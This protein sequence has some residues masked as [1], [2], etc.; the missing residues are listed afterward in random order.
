MTNFDLT[1]PRSPSGRIETDLREAIRTRALKPGD[2]LDTY[3]TL[4]QQYGVDK[5]TVAAAVGRL[6]DQRLVYTKRGVGT[7]VI[8]QSKIGADPN[9]EAALD[10]E[11]SESLTELH[12]KLA[13]IEQRVAALEQENK[14]VPD[15][16]DDHPSK[17][18]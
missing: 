6:R 9:D 1:D 2:R 8:D 11:V 18:T 3:D 5:N 17:S 10:N 15:L 7:F 16:P 13:R 12:R 14:P 4:A